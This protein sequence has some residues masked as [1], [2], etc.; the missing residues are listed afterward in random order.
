MYCNGK[1]AENKMAVNKFVTSFIRNA[2]QNT[3]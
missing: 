2:S 3:A 1:N